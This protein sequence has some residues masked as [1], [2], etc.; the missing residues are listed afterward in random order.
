MVQS[1]IKCLT[2]FKNKSLEQYALKKVLQEPL[3]TKDPMFCEKEA[4]LTKTIITDI[5]F[6][7]ASYFGLQIIVARHKF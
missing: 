3:R 5:N 1:T 7:L 6:L 4:S 2:F